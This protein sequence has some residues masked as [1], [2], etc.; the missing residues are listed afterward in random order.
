MS[1]LLSRFCF[2]K[3]STGPCSP[4][5][6]SCLFITLPITSSWQL[7]YARRFCTRCAPCQAITSFSQHILC[8]FLRCAAFSL[9]SCSDNEHLKGLDRLQRWWK[10]SKPI[11]ASC[12]NCIAAPEITYWFPISCIMFCAGL[13]TG[14]RNEKENQELFL[15]YM[16]QKRKQ[17]L[18]YFLC[19]RT[20]ALIK[21]NGN[22][23]I[24]FFILFLKVFI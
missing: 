14:S 19:S 20:E 13:G 23:L 4:V 24:P 16:E 1:I 15:F 7:N 2:P 9:L 10:S 21:N 11:Q 8:L 5:W 12:T 3:H 17:K 6:C 18:Y 22:W